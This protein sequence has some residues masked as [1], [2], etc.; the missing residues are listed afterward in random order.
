MS[1]ARSRTIELVVRMENKQ[2]VQGTRKTRM[3]P[4]SRVA[5]LVQHVH[6]ILAVRHIAL[7]INVRP[8]A[9]TRPKVR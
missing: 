4:V 3:R 9:T 8:A 1:H 7:R 2:D 6:E 5:E